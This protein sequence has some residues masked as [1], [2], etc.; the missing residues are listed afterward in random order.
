MVAHHP[1]MHRMPHSLET[2]MRPRHGLLSL[3]A[4]LLVLCGVHAQDPSKSRNEGKI[5]GTKWSSL[6]YKAKGQKVPAGL[7]KLEFTKDGNL[8]YQGGPQ[9]FTGKYILKEGY[10]VTLILDQELNGKK[11]HTE[12]VVIE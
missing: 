11:E 4:L 7:V 10:L 9:R 2:V 3:F 5:E 12:K 1:G 6:E 8:V